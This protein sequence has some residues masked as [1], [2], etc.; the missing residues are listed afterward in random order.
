MEIAISGIADDTRVVVDPNFGWSDM[1]AF[2]LAPSLLWKLQL[3]H[4]SNTN[5]SPGARL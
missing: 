2:Y 1:G 4:F 3:S 5:G